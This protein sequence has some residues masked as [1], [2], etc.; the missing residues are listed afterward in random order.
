MAAAEGRVA[1][2]L[3]LGALLVLGSALIAWFL[4]SFERRTERVDAGMSA[5]ARRNPFLAAERF[6]RQVGIASES[7]GGRGPLRD[8]PPTGDALVVDGLGPLNEERRAALQS[9]IEAGGHLFLAPN[10]PAGD[11]VSPRGDLAAAY[12]VR[13]R[14]L[15]DVAP[16]ETVVAKIAFE[17]HREALELELPA[18]RVLLDTR[19][20]ADGAVSAQGHLR[21]L[22]YDVGAGQLTVISDMGAFTNGRIGGRDHAL[23]LALLT[24]R[25]GGGKVW[26]L[27]SSDVPWLGA[28]LWRHA[29]FALVSSGVL[30]LVTLWHLGGR[31]GPLLPS[32]QPRRRDLL[33]HLD[34][35]SEFHWRHGR[36]S[37]LLQVTRQRVQRALLR[38]HPRLRGLTLEERGAWVAHRSGLAV[39][40]VRSALYPSGVSDRGLIAETRV[41]QRLWALSGR[42]EARADRP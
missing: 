27:Y 29:P 23:F 17:H 22:H 16:G 6:L 7:V 15:E 32:P 20:E 28:L 13:L 41:L 24:Q 10:G 26:L 30:T 25:R 11:E 38:R 37:H 19:G 33:A 14:A 34:A 40:R 35:L 31:L 2:L 4:G 39:D 1:H 12:G 21:L 42:R 9:W 18:E 3:V 8:L 5:E 36:G